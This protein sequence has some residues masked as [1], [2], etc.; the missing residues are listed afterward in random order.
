[1]TGSISATGSAVC[2]N[3]FQRSVDSSYYAGGTQR[4]VEYPRSSSTG[5]E[6]LG[7]LTGQDSR[8]DLDLVLND[9]NGTNYRQSIAANRC[10]E[11][12]SVVINPA[13]NYSFVIYLRGVDAQFIANGGRFSGDVATAFTIEI[14]RPK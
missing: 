3:S 7:R 11:K 8:L 13:T 1:L 14:E 5:G 4:C 12:V 10:C 6:I 2:G 9:T